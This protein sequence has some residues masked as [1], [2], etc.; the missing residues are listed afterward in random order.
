MGLVILSAGIMGFLHSVT[1]AH[2]LPVVLVSR[3][4]RWGVRETIQASLVAASGHIATS[5]LLGIS[6]FCF[7]RGLIEDHH[8]SIERFAGIVLLVFGLTYA[9][10]NYREHY[11]CRGHSHHGPEEPESGRAGRPYAFLFV[12][13]FSP[14]LGALPTFLA[15]APFGTSALILTSISFV[16]GVIVALSGAATLVRLGFLKLDQVWLEHYGDVLA[17]LTLAAFGAVN[18]FVVS[19]A[20]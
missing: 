12:A 16:T 5:L 3:K 2:W 10:I 1:P 6:L 11:R 18:L 14:C 13:G 8:E 19:H 20:S 9:A 17:G 7:G 4:R 15:A